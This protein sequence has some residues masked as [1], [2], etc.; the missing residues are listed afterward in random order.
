MNP[1]PATSVLDYSSAAPV[2]R[3]LFASTVGILRHPS[4]AFHWEADLMYAHRFARIHRILA[5]MMLGIGAHLYI[6]YLSGLD[7]FGTATGHWSDGWFW[8]PLTCFWYI[9]FA[10]AAQ[11]SQHGI[12]TSPRSATHDRT[13]MLLHCVH[14]VPP[15]FVIL[16]TVLVLY[17]LNYSF[18]I[19]ASESR[20]A[21]LLILELIM[22]TAYFVL[23]FRIASRNGSGAAGEFNP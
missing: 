19:R 22:G 9:L 4:L 20:Y 3:S 8:I 5:A 15:A 21:I 14:L 13:G 10:A 16:S 1:L 12:E 23:T 2:P 17:R 6:A 7:L 11:I 18:M